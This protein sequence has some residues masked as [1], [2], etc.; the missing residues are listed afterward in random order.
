MLIAFQGRNVRGDVG[1][2]P[3][4]YTSFEPNGAPTTTA[5]EKKIH[6]FE[7]AISKIQV[8]PSSHS[9]VLSSSQLPTPSTSTSST[10]RQ[11]REQQGAGTASASSSHDIQTSRSLRRP[12]PTRVNSTMTSCSSMNTSQ[13]SISPAMMARRSTQYAVT[14]SPTAAFKN[15]QKALSAALELPEL[16]DTSP[17]EWDM[18]QVT[19]WMHAMGF[20]NVAENFKGIQGISKGLGRTSS[21]CTDTCLL[22]LSLPLLLVFSY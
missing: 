13:S 4:N 17:E 11:L 9:N 3:M 19:V 22:S 6:S 12:V 10:E 21:H 1:L 5:L 15:T 2:F 16:K 8:S 7:Q 20:G 18:D 14:R